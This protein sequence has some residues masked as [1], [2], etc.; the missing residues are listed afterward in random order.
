MPQQE[1]PRTRLLEAAGQVFAAQGFE[2]TTVREICKLAEANIAAVN[3]YFRDK[4][5]L[6][7]ESVKHACG[8]LEGVEALESVAR[9]T[10]AESLRAFIHHFVGRLMDEKRPQ[11]HSQLLMRELA[12]PSSACA[13]WVRDCV[14]PVAEALDRLLSQVLPA[15]TPRQQVSLV[16]FSIVGQ[17]LHHLHNRPVIRLLMGEEEFARLDAE[18]VAEHIAAFSLAA[19][20]LGPAIGKPSR[21]ACAKV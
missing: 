13:E 2:G 11:W 1:E 12:Q 16:A 21:S 17:C 4:G 6:Y 3:Y 8:C 7:I 19:L 9:A 18:T 10:P 14:R 15:G 20:G 5:H